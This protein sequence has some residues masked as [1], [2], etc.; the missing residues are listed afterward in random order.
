MCTLVPEGAGEL[1]TQGGLDIIT[2]EDAVRCAVTRLK[3]H[4]I[5]VSIFV[6]PDVVQVGRA[7]AVGGGTGLDPQARR[8][9]PERDPASI[10]RN[11]ADLEVGAPVVHEEHGVGRFLGLVGRQG[12]VSR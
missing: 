2:N 3:E 4:G 8:R 11:L 1:T 12:R 6:D 5:V 10:I 9:R 7:K